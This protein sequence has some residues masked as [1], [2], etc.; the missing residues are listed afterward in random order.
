MQVVVLLLQTY[1][2]TPLNIVLENDHTLL[3]HD[4][5]RSH[6]QRNEKKLLRL[7]NTREYIPSSILIHPALWP[8]QTWP[9]NW[10]CVLFS[11]RGAGF[12]SK[13]MWP[14]PRPTSVPNFILIHPTV[15]PQYTNVTD[16]QD[17]Q[18]RQPSDSIQGEPFYKRS[19]K[20]IILS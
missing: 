9:E 13:Q 7:S 5:R 2:H 20:K 11:L 15:W 10:G 16:R 12:Q 14:G 3:V 17:R 18:A 8:Q 19:P 4:T 1:S 6:T